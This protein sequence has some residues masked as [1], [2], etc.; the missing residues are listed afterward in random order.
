MSVRRQQRPRV[1]YQGHVYVKIYVSEWFIFDLYCICIGLQILSGRSL[2]YYL[3]VEA[4]MA[5][6]LRKNY[7]RAMTSLYLHAHI[8]VRQ[9]ARLASNLLINQPK[10]SFLKDLGLAETNLGAFD[11]KWFGSGEVSFM[12]YFG[13][14]CRIVY[15]FLKL[16][17]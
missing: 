13:H 8:G 15:F 14:E 9:Q 3:L 5:A 12:H 6:L 17:I 7:L 11:G 4:A 10:Y 2:F 1:S 16:I